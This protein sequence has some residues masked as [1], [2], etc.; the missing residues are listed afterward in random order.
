MATGKVGFFPGNY[1]EIR[2]DLD[3]SA[4][5]P[6]TSAAPGALPT[7]LPQPRRDVSSSHTAATVR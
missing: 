6:V 1:V 2:S 5:P 7:D 3:P 4:P